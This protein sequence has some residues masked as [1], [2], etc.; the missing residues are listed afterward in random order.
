MDRFGRSLEV[1]QRLVALHPRKAGHSGN[2]AALTP[3]VVLG[4]ISAFEGFVEDF[5]GNCA[6]ASRLRPRANRKESQHEQSDS[7]S[8]SG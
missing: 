8:L 7:V 4:V 1:P 3:A 6:L 2:F 5:L